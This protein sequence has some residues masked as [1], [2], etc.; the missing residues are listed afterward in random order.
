MQFSV[1]T[2]VS[3]RKTISSL[4]SSLARA[5]LLFPDLIYLKTVHCMCDEEE[6][7]ED[8]TGGW[9]WCIPTTSVSESF[10][11]AQIL[12]KSTQKSGNWHLEEG[13]ELGKS[14]A[15]VNGEV[16]STGRS[17]ALEL[18]GRTNFP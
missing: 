10:S 2:K 7:P 12:A 13:E 4:L 17:K 15:H 8:E 6:D 9:L 5:C 11:V 14:R 1:P 16:K 18:C 3:K